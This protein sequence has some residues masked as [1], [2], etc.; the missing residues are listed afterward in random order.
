[1]CEAPVAMRL[2][3]SH[4]GTWTTV[5]R[6]MRTVAHG[7]TAELARV[8]RERHVTQIVIGQPGRSRLRELVFGSVVNRLLRLPTGADVHVV[9][10]NRTREDEQR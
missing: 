7:Y 3:V 8:A 2:M 9:P 1:M 10:Q 4:G 5:R 6:R